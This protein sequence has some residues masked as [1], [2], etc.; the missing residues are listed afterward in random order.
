MTTIEWLCAL[1]GARIEDLPDSNLASVRLRTAVGIKVVADQ[2]W[3][4]RLSDGDGPSDADIIIVGKIDCVTDPGRLDRW[5]ARLQNAKHKGTRIIIDYTDH[6]LAGNTKTT[7]FY[8]K[9]MALADSVVCSSETLAAAVRERFF[10]NIEVIED[11]IE[12]EITEPIAKPLRPL[13]AL[14]FGHASNLGYLIDYLETGLPKDRPLRLIVMTNAHPLPVAIARR[15]ESPEF[16]QLDV[17]VI[18]WSLHDMQTAASLAD[19]YLLPAGIHDPRKI[20]ASSNRLLTAFALGLPVAADLLPS[21]LPF[22]DQFASLRS[23]ELTSMM[24]S[25][26]GWHPKVTEAQKTISTKFTREAIGAQWLDYLIAQRSLQANQTIP[27]I[28]APAN[29]RPLLE[30]LIITYQQ[31]ALCERMI[32]NIES[33]ASPDIHVLI[34]DDCS[35]DNTYQILHQKFENHPWVKVLRTDRNLGPTGNSSTLIEKASAEYALGIGGDDFI[36]PTE[37]RQAVQQLLQLPTDLAVFPCAHASLECID[38]VLFGQ[39]GSLNRDQFLVRN[40]EYA[41]KKLPLDENFFFRIATIPGAL[42]G[43]GTIFRSDLLKKIQLIKSEHVDEWGIFH[44]LAVYALDKPVRANAYSQ[45]I[46]LLAVMPDS[47]GSDP[48]RQLNRQVNAVIHHWHPRFKK[49]ALINVLA[50]KLEQFRHSNFDAEYLVSVLKQ[51]LTAE[52]V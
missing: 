43:Q 7:L 4:T 45:V 5:V 17:H 28:S 10:G 46:S 44:N 24:A 18:P 36:S 47:R 34:Q 2:G 12:V 23:S 32:A 13:T 39:S 51:S 14:W 31:E 50:K 41:A 6:H 8:Q 15:L 11:P 29:I 38:Q 3:Q 22:R 9:A 37:I 40:A 27:E 1:P 20:G 42:W 35:T 25:P 49:P 52:T 30:V 48:V 33:Y 16:S 21:Y 19:F 26:E